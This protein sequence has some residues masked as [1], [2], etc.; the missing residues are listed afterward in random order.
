MTCLRRSSKPHWKGDPLAQLLTELE[1][2]D[3]PR[4]R[5]SE[6]AAPAYTLKIN[7]GFEVIDCWT[8]LHVPT[9]SAFCSVF[10][11]VE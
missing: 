4:G 8:L 7:F 6:A 5:G 10:I 9:H 11:V 1:G 2:D 3:E